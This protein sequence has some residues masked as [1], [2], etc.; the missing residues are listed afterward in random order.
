MLQH[1]RGFR[2]SVT[3][4]TDDNVVSVALIFESRMSIVRSAA[5]KLLG[6][7]IVAVSLGAL[8]SRSKCLSEFAYLCAYASAEVVRRNSTF[9]EI[10]GIF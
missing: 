4:V 9:L 6:R 5:T 7:L 3:S 10:D 8:Q 1:V 2:I